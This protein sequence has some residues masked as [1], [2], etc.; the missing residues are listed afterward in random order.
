M[1][2][3]AIGEMFCE[4]MLLNSRLYRSPFNQS[5]PELDLSQIHVSVF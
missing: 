3:E 2:G 4:T 1:S 5:E